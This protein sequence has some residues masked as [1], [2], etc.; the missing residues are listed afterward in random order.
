MTLYTRVVRPITRTYWKI[1]PAALALH[2]SS[3]FM[4]AFIAALDSSGVVLSFLLGAWAMAVVGVV[5]SDNVIQTAR[6]RECAFT[7]PHLV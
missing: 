6:E 5:I 1:V 2:A 4:R 3:G 7:A